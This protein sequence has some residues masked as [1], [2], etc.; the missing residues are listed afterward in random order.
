MKN[1]IVKAN[2][3]YIISLY[4]T[5]YIYIYIYIYIKVGSGSNTYKAI[6]KVKKQKQ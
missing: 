4:N 5:Y 1:L 6:R 2:I 3:I